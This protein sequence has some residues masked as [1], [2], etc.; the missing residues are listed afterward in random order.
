MHARARMPQKMRWTMQSAQQTNARRIYFPAEPPLPRINPP[1][2]GPTLGA[3]STPTQCPRHMN[4]NCG[5]MRHSH[6]P[7]RFNAA[8]ASA[9]V[10]HVT[11]SH[12]SPVAPAAATRC[13]V[14]G[15]R[16]RYTSKEPGFD[17]SVWESN[18]M[19]K[20]RVPSHAAGKVELEDKQQVKSKITKPNTA[21][22]I[23][24]LRAIIEMGKIYFDLSNKNLS[25]TISDPQQKNKQHHLNIT[26]KKQ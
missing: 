13:D 23:P 11:N 19:R 5:D 20:C 3:R 2:H 18:H 15:C 25:L 7:N 24:Q 22:Y 8:A 12:T 26:S 4:S 6:T 1:A 14:C 16:Y 17:M 10:D 21:Y 9:S